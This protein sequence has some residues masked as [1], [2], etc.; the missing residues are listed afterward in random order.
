M[1]LSVIIPCHN[2]EKFI[3]PLLDSFNF[4]KRI[5]YYKVE[6]IFVCD[7]C[8]DNTR[9]IIEEYEFIDDYKVKIIDAHVLSCGLARN[10][11]LEEATGRYIWFV[12]GDDWL[13]DDLAFSRLIEYL[14]FTEERA[15]RFDYTAPG[16]PHHGVP[17]MVWQY[18]FKRETI[19]DIRFTKIQPSEDI[20]F[21]KKVFPTGSTTI[22]AINT[23]IY[24][25]NYMREGSNI[26][27]FKTKGFI[28][29]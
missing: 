12:D 14:D 6:L 26:Q 8:V 24:Y 22:R 25:Y 23:K 10:V 19:G 2:L 28:E 5:E 7:A 16:F 18:V 13:I 3:K 20:E 17:H 27:Q 11:G 29:P 9:K 15:V 4:Q 21:I 1:D